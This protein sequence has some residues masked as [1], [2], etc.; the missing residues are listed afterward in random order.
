MPPEVLTGLQD[1]S[2][3]ACE[4]VMPIRLICSSIRL[5]E[6]ELKEESN[7]PLS[8]GRST[9]YEALSIMSESQFPGGIKGT[10]REKRIQVTLQCLMRL[11]TDP[12]LKDYT[13]Y[14]NIVLANYPL[15]LNLF[16]LGF[17]HLKLKKL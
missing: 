4:P 13:K 6:L 8:C 16:Y 2:P 5:V 1:L 14:P 17:Y 12:T 10:H 15:G 11:R 3:L 7:L 9:E